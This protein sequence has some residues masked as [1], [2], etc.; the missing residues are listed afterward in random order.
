M[1]IQRMEL[2]AISCFLHV[3]MFLGMYVDTLAY[4]LNSI[5]EGVSQLSVWMVWSNI[6][7]LYNAL[8]NG[9]SSLRLLLAG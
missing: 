1:I 9:D 4:T 3:C 8:I 5:L 2:L 7:Q 6:R